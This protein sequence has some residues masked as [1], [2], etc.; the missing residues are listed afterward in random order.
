M[1]M[2]NYNTYI[3]WH[4]LIIMTNKK[5]TEKEYVIIIIIN[6][7]SGTSWLNKLYYESMTNAKETKEE[8]VINSYSKFSEW[9]IL[10]IESVL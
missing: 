10:I 6:A 4:I 2:N 8:Y 3:E 7:L 1:F 5:K 9:H